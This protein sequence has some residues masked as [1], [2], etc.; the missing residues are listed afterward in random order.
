MPAATPRK[1]ARI[2]TVMIVPLIDI[3]IVLLIFLTAT[4]TLK[5]RQPLIPLTLP[6][7]K[8]AGQNQ[9]APP[10]IFIV[11]ISSNEPYFYLE[12]G[13][14]PISEIRQRLEKESLENSSLVVSLRADENAPFGK[15]VELMDLAKELKIQSIQAWT[16]SAPNQR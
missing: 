13:P 10:K 9:E 7:T 12:Q 11:S 2:P 8:N 15:I 4:T 1:R 5:K 16:T 6:A 3:L 14:M